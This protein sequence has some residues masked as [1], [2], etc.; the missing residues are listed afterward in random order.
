M[1]LSRFVSFQNG[2]IIVECHVQCSH[3]LAGEKLLPD[4]F[5]DE[6]EDFQREWLQT[7]KD[8]GSSQASSDTAATPPAGETP[9][10]VFANVK[11]LL[12]TE[13]VGQIKATYL[14]V[15]DG[16]HPGECNERFLTCLLYTSPSPR[17]ATLSRMP[18]S[19]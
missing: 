9:E 4:Y 1:V 18:S 5:L 12:N 7:Q 13:I 14:F 8:A 3:T 2:G 17:D 16:D 15:V 10:A 19:A 6:A 11:T